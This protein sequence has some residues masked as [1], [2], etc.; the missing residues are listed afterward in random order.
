MQP[1]DSQQSSLTTAP[2]HEQQAPISQTHSGENTVPMKPM[3]YVLAAIFGASILIVL[4][5][6]VFRYGFNNS[7]TWSE[8][9]CRY[10]F[11]WLVFIGAALA[12]RDKC[13]ITVD[14]IGWAPRRWQHWAQV[15]QHVLVLVFLGVV[16]VLGCRWVFH[17]AGTHSPVLGL[18]V[19]WVFYAAL[20]A[21]CLLALVY[22]IRALAADRRRNR[23]TDDAASEDR[24]WRG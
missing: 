24:V 8:E 22:A 14:L 15:L 5:Q 13:H 6:V 4:L 23:V 16:A 18:P 3:D 1:P 17:T 2:T 20:P 11:A 7:L 9:V 12:L 10:L 19:N 21:G